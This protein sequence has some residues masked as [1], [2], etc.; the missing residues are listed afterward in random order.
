MTATQVPTVRFGELLGVA[1]RHSAST[2]ERILTDAD[3][4]FVEWVAFTYL[5]RLGGVN[6]RADLISDIAA[7][8]QND[9][10]MVAAGIERLIGKQMLGTM[11]ANGTTLVELTA[12]G[13]EFYRVLGVRVDE[14]SAFE[15][16][17]SSP[18]DIEAARRVLKQFSEQAEM[19]NR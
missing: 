9:P 19:L 2:F 3:T 8:T 11:N 6:P 13:A 14:I 1:A 10:E 18:E 5:T 7:R 16:S 17:T 12:E 15:L 4:P